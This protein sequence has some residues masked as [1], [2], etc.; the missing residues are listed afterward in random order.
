MNGKILPMYLTT[1]SDIHLWRVSLEELDPP[2]LA[3]VLSDDERRRAAKFRFEQHRQE[4]VAAR[5][6]LRHVLAAYVGNAPASL[7]F[8]YGEHGKPALDGIEFNLSHSGA[9]ALI[10]VSRSRIG[11]DLERVD[12]N[13]RW[14]EIAAVFFSP[15]EGKMIAAQPA[16]HRVTAFL[17]CWT[18]REAYLKACGSGLAASGPGFVSG[19]DPYGSECWIRSLEPFPGYIGAVACGIERFAL[20]IFDW[21]FD[22]AWRTPVSAMPEPAGERCSVPQRPL[23]IND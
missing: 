12:P 1:S 7:Q 20:E 23:N 14:E 21:D 15:Q 10:A 5:A 3:R 22:L 17:R 6:V 4:F 16:P 11:V 19:A 9:K 8:R 18:R 2:S 13:F